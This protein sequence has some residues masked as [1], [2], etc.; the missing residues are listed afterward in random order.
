VTSTTGFPLTPNSFINW[1]SAQQ[2]G[3]AVYAIVASVVSGNTGTTLSV[4]GDAT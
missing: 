3:G 1:Y 2:L 4:T